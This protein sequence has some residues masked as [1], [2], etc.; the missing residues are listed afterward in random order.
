MCKIFGFSDKISILSAKRKNPIID[1]RVDFEIKYKKA[2]AKF[3][4]VNEEKQKIKN[5]ID[6]ITPKKKVSFSFRSGKIFIYNKKG[7]KK[8]LN[9]QMNI[10]QYN[11]FD[12]ISRYLKKKE[13]ILCNPKDALKVEIILNKI[14]KNI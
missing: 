5:E 13:K 12:N 2:T 11:V 4:S 6:I 1:S 9:T 3:F 14:L 7:R 10:S 8:I